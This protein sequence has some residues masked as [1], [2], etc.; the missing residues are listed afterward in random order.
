VG[1]FERKNGSMS[2]TRKVIG[3]ANN[4]QNA[5]FTYNECGIIV[6]HDSLLRGII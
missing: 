4:T 6:N 1:E 5:I 3:K 2:I